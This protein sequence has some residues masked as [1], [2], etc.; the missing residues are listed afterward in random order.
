[1]IESFFSIVSANVTGTG[2]FLNFYSVHK[3]MVDFIE[4]YKKKIY[5][6]SNMTIEEFKR[7]L[8]QLNLADYVMGSDYEKNGRTYRYAGGSAICQSSS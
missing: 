8:S 2:T 4:F 5:G 6:A 3:T 1:V 7:L